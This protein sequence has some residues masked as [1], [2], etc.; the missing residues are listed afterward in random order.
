MP[1]SPLESAD[2]NDR[3]DRQRV[4]G[5]DEESVHA[6]AQASRGGASGALHEERDGHRDH[7]EDAGGEQGGES[8][9]DRLDNQRPER[10]S[11]RG[12]LLHG[13]D[14]RGKAFLNVLFRYDRHRTF[15][16][17]NRQIQFIRKKT[18]RFIANHPR[19]IRPDGSLVNCKFYFLCKTGHTLERSDPSEAIRKVV[20]GR[21]HLD[22]A[23]QLY[24]RSRGYDDGRGHRPSFAVRT[25]IVHV[26]LPGNFSIEYNTVN[27]LFKIL[28]RTSPANALSHSHG[29]NQRQEKR[30]RQFSYPFSHNRPISRKNGSQSENRDPFSFFNYLIRFR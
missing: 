18:T 2:K 24:S 30:Q 25:H 9:E 22:P 14:L 27:V 26:I 1:A 6:G 20:R 4:E 17:G 15:G 29:G 13:G 23:D 8:P 3:R 11:A 12:I 10:T 5:Y 21:K 7:R 28:D 19:K 16:N